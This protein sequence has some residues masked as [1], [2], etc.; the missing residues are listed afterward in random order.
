[1]SGKVITW[2]IGGMGVAS[3]DYVRVRVEKPSGTQ[4]SSF[5]AAEEEWS[6]RLE[7]VPD[8]VGIE[9]RQKCVKPEYCEHR[10]KLGMAL[11]TPL[12]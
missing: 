4:P 9:S 12:I 11:V 10:D 5:F 8:L 7:F 3:D 2:K 1:M 6:I